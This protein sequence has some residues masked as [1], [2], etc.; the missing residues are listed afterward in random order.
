MNDSS[1]RLICIAAYHNTATGE[2]YV[3]SDV[4]EVTSDRAAFLLRDAPGCFRCDDVTFAPVASAL[5]TDD[6]TFSPVASALGTEVEVEAVTPEFAGGSV[7]A[8]PGAT[9]AVLSPKRRRG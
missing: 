6:V 9:A 7:V 4:L 2:R 5:G 3:R 1:V 8:F